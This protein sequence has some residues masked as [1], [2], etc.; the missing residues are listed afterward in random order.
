M[1]SAHEAEFSKEV[2]V[3]F[4]EAIF[5]NCS[6]TSAITPLPIHWRPGPGGPIT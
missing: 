6:G 3:V 1:A 2:T 5:T 4:C